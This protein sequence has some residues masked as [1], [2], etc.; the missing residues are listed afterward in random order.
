MNIENT[1]VVFTGPIAG[2]NEIPP[3][4]FES[5]N[6]RTIDLLN[7]RSVMVYELPYPRKNSLLE[8]LLFY[9][10]GFFILNLK[11]IFYRATNLNK[12]CICHI[13]PLYK[14]FLYIETITILLCKLLKYKIIYDIRAGSLQIYYNNRGRVYKN[15]VNAIIK[16]CDQIAIE[17]LEYQKFIKNISGSTPFYF[18]NYVQDTTSVDSVKQRSVSIKNNIEIVY[19]GRVTPE[20]GIDTCIQTAQNLQDRGYNCLLSIIGPASTTYRTRLQ[21]SLTNFV[22]LEAGM[23]HDL[24]FRTIE[25]CHFFIFPTSHRGE[26]HSNALTEAMAHGCVPVSSDNGFNKSVINDC[27]IVIPVNSPSH[28]Y[29]DSI[30]TIVDSG[31][32]EEYSM[33]NINRVKK[34]YLAETIIPGIIQL[35][36]QL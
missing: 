4:G 32:W 19:F 7:A 6:R 8:K 28:I 33:K 12:K 2:K 34:L 10:I 27:G 24:L 13:T 26:G 36:D 29:A 14:R 17:G 3:G 22:S 30:Q 23:Q 9:P 35:Y 11:I 25:K 16:S 31:S 20:K 5:A 15:F 18:P 1:V 21:Q